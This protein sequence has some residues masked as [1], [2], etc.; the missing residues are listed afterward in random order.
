VADEQPDGIVLK[1]MRD[2]E[3][4]GWHRWVRRSLLALVAL[5]V[6][7]GLLNAF[8][9]RPSSATASNADA[10]LKV[11]GPTRVRSGLLWQARFTIH[12][13]RELKDAQL[14]LSQ[15]W[16]E[17]NTINTIEPAPIGEASRNGSLALDLGHVPQG[18]RYE[19]YMQFQTNPTNVGRRSADVQ[20]QDG[21]RLVLSIH[22]TLTIFP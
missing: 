15:G 20:L 3:G 4:R 2:M 9:Q 8:G 17:S 10:S 18:E 7:A 19:L 14:V 1:R 12:A 21:E 16:L 6:L 11:Y 22:R 13:N 5:F